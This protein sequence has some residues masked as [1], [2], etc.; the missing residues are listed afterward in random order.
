[1]D[2]AINSNI[3]MYQHLQLVQ[4]IVGHSDKMKAKI[5]ETNATTLRDKDIDLNKKQKNYRK[6]GT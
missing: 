2:T 4:Q 1:M 6:L 5:L 3:L